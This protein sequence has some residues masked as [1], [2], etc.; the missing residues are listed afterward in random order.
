MVAE[1]EVDDTDASKVVIALVVGGVLREAHDDSDDVPPFFT[2]CCRVDSCNI[3]HVGSP[4]VPSGVH[5]V[6][7]RFKIQLPCSKN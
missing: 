5:P 6:D 2:G 4:G 1:V 7:A 3:N